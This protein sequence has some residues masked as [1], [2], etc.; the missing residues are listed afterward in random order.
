MLEWYELIP[1][2]PPPFG[3]HHNIPFEHELA[4]DRNNYTKD[5]TIT[6]EELNEKYKTEILDEVNIL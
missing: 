4:K 1:K 5:V 2:K 3:F 6:L